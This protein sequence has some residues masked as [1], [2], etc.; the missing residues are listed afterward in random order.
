MT[1]DD[2]VAALEAEVAALRRE[3]A[4][5]ARTDQLTGL[6]NR[7]HLDEHLDMVASGARRLKAAITLLLV[8]VDRLKRVN[9]THGLAAGDAVLRAVAER[10]A[11]GLR[12]EDMA[13][14]WGDEELLVILPH[15]P[16][17]GGWRLADRIRQSVCDAP[18]P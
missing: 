6:S 3:L 12:G 2:A 1:T 17:D 16:L 15:T 8:D 10:V 9:E 14:R 18:V 11:S 5:L 13:G 4:E 7:R